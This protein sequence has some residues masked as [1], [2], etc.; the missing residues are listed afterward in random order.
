[1]RPTHGPVSLPAGSA[2]SVFRFRAMSFR[3]ISNL[4]PLPI[5]RT[6]A[7][8]VNL[9]KLTPANVIFRKTL[10]ISRGILRAWM[11]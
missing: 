2:I 1:M 9:L 11:T 3:L 6:R 7:P 5:G 4:P 8:T 10:V